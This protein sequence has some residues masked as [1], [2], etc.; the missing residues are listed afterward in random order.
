[1]TAEPRAR[2]RR[3]VT[4]GEGEVVEWPR[5]L[6]SYVPRGRADADPSPEE[7][8][9]ANRLVLASRLLGLLRARGEPVDREILRLRAAERAFAARDRKTATELVDQLLGEL[10]SRGHTVERPRTDR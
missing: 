5:G 6:V 8:R 4:R 7:D 3:R 2:R 1:M 9:T 10:E